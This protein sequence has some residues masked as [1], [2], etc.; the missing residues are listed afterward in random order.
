MGCVRSE[1]VHIGRTRH[2]FCFKKQSVRIHGVLEN[3][4]YMYMPF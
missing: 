4:V 1:E 2:T 3:G